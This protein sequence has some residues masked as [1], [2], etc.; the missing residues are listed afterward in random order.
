MLFIRMSGFFLAILLFVDIL[1]V[2]L[3]FY[4]DPMNILIHVFK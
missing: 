1:A 2:I 4:R 3:L